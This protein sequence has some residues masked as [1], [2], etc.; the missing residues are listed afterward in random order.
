VWGSAAA[1]RRGSGRDSLDED[2]RERRKIEGRRHLFR[3]EYTL[4]LGRCV[5]EGRERK[6]WDERGQGRSVRYTPPCNPREALV[7]RAVRCIHPL[8]SLLIFI[9]GLCFFFSIFLCF[10]P[11][12]ASAVTWSYEEHCRRAGVA[13]IDWAAALDASHAPIRA[14]EVQGEISVLLKHN[15]SHREVYEEMCE[16]LGRWHVWGV[17]I[18]GA[19]TD[20]SFIWRKRKLQGILTRYISATQ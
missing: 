10:Y 19:E 2:A 20:I 9:S 15:T 14:H 16:R 5:R 18:S 17:M 11:C 12:R 13:P 3:S 7:L 1:G 6:Y 4:E 8:L